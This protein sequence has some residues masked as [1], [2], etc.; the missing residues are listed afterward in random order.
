MH[1]WSILHTCHYHCPS[2]PI[3]LRGLEETAIERLDNVRGTLWEQSIELSL[4][5]SM[6]D[7][8]VMCKLH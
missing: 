6:P 2:K 1:A 3:G 4:A 5:E 8:G 7:L